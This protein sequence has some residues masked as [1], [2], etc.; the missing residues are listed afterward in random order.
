MKSKI[1][2]LGIFCSVYFVFAFVA[3]LVN[4]A[5]GGEVVV[6]DWS[7][8]AKLILLIGV[9]ISYFISISGM[10]DED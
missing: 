6:C 8:Y 10:I 1:I 3:F 5:T 7:G 2:R 9:P 4:A